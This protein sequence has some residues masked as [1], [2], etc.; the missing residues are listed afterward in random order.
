MSI[1]V[2]IAFALFGVLL[3]ADLVRGVVRDFRRQ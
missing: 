2:Q 3:V 1:E